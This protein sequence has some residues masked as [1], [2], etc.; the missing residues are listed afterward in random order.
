MKITFDPHGS[1]VP[2]SPWFYLHTCVVAKLNIVLD[3]AFSAKNSH[4]WSTA[5]NLLTVYFVAHL[6]HS[7]WQK[8]PR[9]IS[10]PLFK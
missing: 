3:I 10:S 5:A 4:K 7:K 2:M 6:T 8:P 1:K 9:R